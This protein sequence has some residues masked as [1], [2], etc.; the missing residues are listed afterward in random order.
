MEEPRDPHDLA[1]ALPAPGSDFAVRPARRSDAAF[2]ASSWLRSYR[3]APAV[4]AVPSRT[5]FYWQHRV[6]EAL[7][8]RS[9]VLV[10][11]SPDDPDT[12]VGWACA[13]AMEGALV[14]HYVYVKHDFR[15]YGVARALVRALQEAE[16]GS[17]QLFATHATR[18]AL[19]VMRDN[20]VF[21][22][23]FLMMLPF[24]DG[25]DQ[26]PAGDPAG[27]EPPPETDEERERHPR[28]E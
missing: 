13:E 5:Y 24:V 20:G 21:Y 8:A 18:K 2:V 17:G 19:R 23:P 4:V 7:L 15:R 27:G 3:D 6:V 26:L 12:I 25:S 16:P 28:A 11:C 22:N 1:G 14:L 9:A 10:A